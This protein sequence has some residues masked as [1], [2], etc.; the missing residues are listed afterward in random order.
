[1]KEFVEEKEFKNKVDTNSVFD[2]TWNIREL[3]AEVKGEQNCPFKRL[4]ENAD[5]LLLKLDQLRKMVK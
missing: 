2:I 5:R 4:E 1:M 3:S